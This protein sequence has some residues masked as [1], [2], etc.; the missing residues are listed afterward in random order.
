MPRP[1]GRET[2][3][4]IPDREI[5]QITDGL[6]SLT[7]TQLDSMLRQAWA[8]QRSDKQHVADLAREQIPRIESEMLRR[9]EEIPQEPKE[10]PQAE[11]K[12]RKKKPHKAKK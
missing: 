12:S 9:G 5:D 6:R 2:P 4:V 1:E 11:P 7:V 8:S 10:S 3:P